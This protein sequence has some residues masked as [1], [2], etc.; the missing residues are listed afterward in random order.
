MP[1]FRV[2]VQ[3]RPRMWC[4]TDVLRVLM[5]APGGAQLISLGSHRLSVAGGPFSW[6]SEFEGGSSL[7][8]GFR[9]LL[10]DF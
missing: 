10:G 5:V 1:W 8:A 2:G 7:L 3:V 6:C 9:V 4:L